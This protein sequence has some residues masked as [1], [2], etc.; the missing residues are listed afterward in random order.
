[1]ARDATAAWMDRLVERH[2]A[3]RFAAPARGWSSMLHVRYVVDM[4]T[5][6]TRNRG[7]WLTVYQV[8][9]L[10]SFAASFK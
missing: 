5:L 9:G 3:Q 8:L 10:A 1:M 4:T 6:R 7:N 2:P